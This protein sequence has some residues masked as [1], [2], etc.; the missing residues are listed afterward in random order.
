MD[1]LTSVVGT[2]LFVVIF[3]IVSARASQVKVITPRLQKPPAKSER[4][5]FLCKDGML[6][7]FD[8]DGGKRKLMEGLD[9]LSYDNAPS[10]VK[11]ANARNVIDG[12]FSYKLAYDDWGTEDELYRSISLVAQ[13]VGCEMGE[14]V[15]DLDKPSSNFSR[16]LN[17]L[18]KS[19]TWVAFLVDQKSI[20]VFYTARKIAMESGFA[21]GWDPI[22]I[23]S[24][25]YKEC[26]IGCP[27][28]ENKAAGVGS[29]VQ[30]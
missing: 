15:S 29:G 6:R 19:K 1:L 2:M 11:K 25:P 13:P 10:V 18:D 14:V 4:K 20:A 22:S 30:W 26:I 12:C 27:G 24:F 21:S 9:K 16:S 23:I 8:W 28:E 5:I 7:P 17:L 3:A